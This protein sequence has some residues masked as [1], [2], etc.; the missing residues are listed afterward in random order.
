[1]SKNKPN[2]LVFTGRIKK[3][4]LTVYRWKDR[5]I[6]RPSISRQPE[7]RTRAQF[8]LRQRLGHSI[9]LWQMLD[10]GVKPMFNAGINAYARFRSLAMALP[11]VYLP[12]DAKAQGASLL[13]PDMPVSEGTLP[14]VKQWLGEVEGEAALL[15]GLQEIP[16]RVELR[17]YQLMQRM[18]GRWPVLRIGVSHPTKADFQQVEGGLALVGSQFADAMTGWALVMVQGERCST[19]RALSRCELYK[20][21]TTEAAYREALASYGGL[22]ER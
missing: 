8:D 19:Q 15:T 17:L 18:E 14:E 12:A 16:R 5:T 9:V 10:C 6:A 4:G 3:A 1:M 11:T 20:E 7:R 21:Y 22:K 2:G 13:L